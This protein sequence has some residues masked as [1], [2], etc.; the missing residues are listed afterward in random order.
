MNYE[1]TEIQYKMYD[2]LLKI[3][4]NYK[5]LGAD[6]STVFIAD[7]TLLSTFQ[8]ILFKKSDNILLT[9]L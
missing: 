1:F 7:Q 2:T 5:P 9:K 4:I 8:L 3:Y 6:T